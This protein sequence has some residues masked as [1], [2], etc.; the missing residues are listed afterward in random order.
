MTTLQQTLRAHL[1]KALNPFQDQCEWIDRIMTQVVEN[2][3]SEIANCDH[4]WKWHGL[5]EAIS[6][7]DY[8]GFRAFA[9]GLINGGDNDHIICWTNDMI[10]FDMV[11]AC[12]EINGVYQIV[13]VIRN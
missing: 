2:T 11:Y 9:K 4:E 8:A 12:C 7:T 3:A 1:E 10:N 13:H 6:L 5:S